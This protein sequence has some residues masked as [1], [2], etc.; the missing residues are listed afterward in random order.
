MGGATYLHLNKTLNLHEKKHFINCFSS[1]CLILVNKG[2]ITK[3]RIVKYFESFHFLMKVCT[4]SFF[5]TNT[6][7]QTELINDKYSQFLI[8]FFI[9][10][11]SEYLLNKIIS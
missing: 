11:D 2:K 6:T 8:Y 1:H 9:E 10:K 4:H 7:V 3:F 5:Y